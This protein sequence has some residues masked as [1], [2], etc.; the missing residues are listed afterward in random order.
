MVANA[1]RRGTVVDT[2][3][4]ATANNPARANALRNPEV[5][6]HRLA[7]DRAEADTAVHGDGEVRRRLS[8]VDRA[9]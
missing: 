2:S 3:A 7:D 1:T 5:L 4:A 9:G 6:E 8:A